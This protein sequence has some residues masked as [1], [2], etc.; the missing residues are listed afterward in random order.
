ME[1]ENQLKWLEA[2]PNASKSELERH[3]KNA[4]KICQA[5]MM[6]IHGAGSG[7]SAAKP[8]SPAGPRIEEVD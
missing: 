4:Q 3:L 8:D 2:N 5:S 1:C 7:P 6:K